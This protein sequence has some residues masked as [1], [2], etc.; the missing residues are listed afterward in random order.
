[1]KRGYKI[2]L[3]V[4]AVIGGIFCV[5][6]IIG[7]VGSKL[8]K[9]TLEQCEGG[10]AMACYS[11]AVDYRIGDEGKGIEK[12]LLKAV[13]YEE[14]ACELGYFQQ[15]ESIALNADIN[16]DMERAKKFYQKACEVGKNNPKVQNSANDKKTWEEACNRPM[17]A[18][19]EIADYVKKCE[20]GDMD[21][22]NLAGYIY[23]S[24]ESITTK[25]KIRPDY[26]EAMKLYNKSCDNNNSGGCFSVATMII[27]KRGIK[28][29]P[30][31]YA[32]KTKAYLKKACDAE[33]D[34]IWNA[35]G[36]YAIYETDIKEMRQY[37]K[38]ACEL[39]KKTDMSRNTVKEESLIRD[40]C[41]KGS[42]L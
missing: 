14:K 27:N 39:G 15:C 12:D 10:D 42:G 19:D 25:E 34:P 20:G 32:D 37:Y 2:L 33:K 5:L 28:G 9:S 21:S 6:L 41:A 24:G 35:C 18:K 7:F 26:A 36:L 23:E 22:C 29:S 13:E 8:Q 38:R 17:S 16:G 31:Q 30:Y 4:F 1:M 3:G 11:V 40:F